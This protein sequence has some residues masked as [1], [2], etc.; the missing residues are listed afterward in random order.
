MSIAAVIAQ[1]IAQ[2]VKEYRESPSAYLDGYIDG[3]DWALSVVNNAWMKD[4]E[5]R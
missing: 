2:K 1:E 5:S 4:R 3:L